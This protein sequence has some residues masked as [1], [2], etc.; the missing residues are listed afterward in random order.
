[1]HPSV[2]VK[3][4]GVRWY[5]FGKIFP[6]K[7]KSTIEVKELA[8]IALKGTLSDSEEEKYLL[9]NLYRDLKLNT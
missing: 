7:G 2:A 8:Y 6:V 1:L 3:K 4:K 5:T 9:R